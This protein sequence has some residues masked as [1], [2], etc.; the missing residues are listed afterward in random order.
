MRLML[1]SDESAGTLQLVLLAAQGSSGSRVLIF[2]HSSSGS[3]YAVKCTQSSR[4][5]LVDEIARRASLV[6]LLGERLPEVLSCQIM[7]G[8][9]VMIS[10]CKG[11]QTLHNMILHSDIPQ[12]RLFS[13]WESVVDDLMAVWRASA[14]QPFQQDLCPRYLPA[15]LTRIRTSLQETIIQGV[16]LAEVWHEPTF[17]NGK[18][19]ISIAEAFSEI[20]AIG[21][22]T[23]GVLCHGDPQP[24]NVLVGEN[25]K[26]FL[27]DWEWSGYHHD[28]RG[29]VSHLLGWWSSRFLVLQSEPE[30]KLVPGRG[31]EISFEA[32][33]P[34]HIE[35]YQQLVV[36]KLP[37]SAPEPVTRDVL[38]DIER[39]LAVLYFGELRFLAVWGRQSFSV[40][41][42]A[43]ALI[44]ASH[45][46]QIGQPYIV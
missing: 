30:L 40:P 23:V 20:E 14:S 9:E 33:V 29:M 21:H 26:W 25:D 10:E 38:S 19:Y 37:D 2:R 39:M 1:K 11:L 45:K 15:R 32:F 4:V 12:N 18:Q 22:P 5:A 44:A 34:Q 6:S 35:K 42:L 41:M 46:A 27:I 28:W 36:S 17:I 31:L 16:S 7:D 43:N 24:S 3:L 13:I 8:Y